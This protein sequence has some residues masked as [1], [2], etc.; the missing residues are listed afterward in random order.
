[1][2]SQR[3]WKLL[4]LSR[5]IWVRTTL[6][7]L[8]AVFAV[9]VSS[10][11]GMFIPEELTDRFGPDAVMP[12]LNILASSMLAVVTFSLSVMVAA[13]RQASSQVTPRAHRLLL[14]D[15]TTQTVLA[16]FLG[17]FIFSLLGIVMYRAG[18]YGARDA[19][20]VFA[21]TALVIVLVVVAILRWISHLSRLGSMDE[22]MEQLES[23]VQRT[24]HDHRKWPGLGAEC[25]D[26]LT[27][28]PQGAVPIRAA[29]TGYVRHVDIASVQAAAEAR[30][31]RVFLSAIPGDWVGE[32]DAVAHVD[33]AGS[34][35]AERILAAY[36][37]SALRNFDQDPRFGLFVMAEIGARALSPG[38]NDPGTAIEVIARMER[39]LIR[40][41][42]DAV[43]AEA[44]D[45]TNVRVRR[46]PELDLIDDSITMLARDGAGMVEVAS[47]LLG[48]LRRL[49]RS[50]DPEVSNAAR[51]LATYAI[52]AAESALER[53]HDLKRLHG[54]LEGWGS[55]ERETRTE[56]LAVHRAGE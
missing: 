37:F 35:I 29:D 33:H 27:G 25:Y 49:A 30:G 24:L 11:L 42:P 28:P 13:F 21:F 22:T 1:M 51:E 14:E 53:E 18:F 8:L 46:L 9:G 2:L 43:V 56:P 52:A 5:K 12:I 36:T 48:T 55:F 45:Y 41:A 20:V 44:P 19:V 39:L 54:A 26:P 16:T 23:R 17:A 40:N 38:I 10:V 32:G 47:R 3:L 50:R 34:D 4:Q 6:I 31:C 15:T 7:S